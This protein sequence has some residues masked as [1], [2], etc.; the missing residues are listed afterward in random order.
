MGFCN[1]YIDGFYFWL[2]RYGKVGIDKDEYF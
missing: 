2:W 1:R